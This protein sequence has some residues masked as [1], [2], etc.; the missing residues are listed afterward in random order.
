MGVML[1][2]CQPICTTPAIVL[3]KDWTL[4]WL[5]NFDH[6]VN[7]PTDY[8]EASFKAECFSFATSMEQRLVYHGDNLYVFLVSDKD[9]WNELISGGV[10]VKFG[11]QH[12]AV[13][14]K[15]KSSP[16]D[17]VGIH[18]SGWKKLDDDTLTCIDSDIDFKFGEELYYILGTGFGSRPCSRS[19]AVNIYFGGRSSSQASP[20]PGIGPKKTGEHQYFRSIWAKGGKELQRLFLEKSIK[21]LPVIPQMLD[22]AFNYNSFIGTG[23][24]DKTI[25]TQGIPGSYFSF[26]NET[27]K[28]HRDFIAPELV[29]FWQTELSQVDPNLHHAAAV[30]NKIQRVK[31]VLGGFPLPTTCAYLHAWERNTGEEALQFLITLALVF[32]KE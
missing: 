27:H 8:D 1:P 19:K 32:Q 12:E 22:L 9:E 20:S 13:L 11:A 29:E 17:I 28:D 31:E 5:A 18:V 23:I 14:S 30:S 21:R 3:P 25:W 4:Q 26:C 10:H 15:T 2:I 6:N 24:C 16:M 7:I